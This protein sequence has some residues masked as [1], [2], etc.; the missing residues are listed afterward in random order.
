MAALC[1]PLASTTDPLLSQE[2]KQSFRQL[3]SQDEIQTAI[4]NMAARI[5]ADLNGEEVLLLVVLKGGMI[6]ASDLVRQLESPCTMECIRAKSYGMGG[7]QRGE[8]T[9]T[10]LE[11]LSLEGKNVL[12]VED[13]FDTGVTLSTIMEHL[14][15]FAPKTLRS[16]TLLMRRVEHLTDYRPDYCLFEIEDHFVI[17]YGFDYK[18]RWR[19]LPAVYM[20]H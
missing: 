2:A 19:N 8:L 12:V 16:V 10:G 14:K 15:T 18:E 6:F 3:I 13:I 11:G 17:G 1:A 7:D 9:I 20:L 5:D 4:Q